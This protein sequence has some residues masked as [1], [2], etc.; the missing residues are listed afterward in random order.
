[1]RLLIVEDEPRM[2]ALLQRGFAEE[3]YA[4]DVVANGADSVIACSATEY[5]VVVLDVLLPDVDGFEVCHRLRQEGCW[6]PILML[7]ARDS[8]GDRV[9][10]L[11][12][13]LTITWSSPLAS[14]R[15]APAC[16]L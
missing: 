13:G 11:D 6:T 9:R 12:A 5:D 2:A 15:S 14:R 7:T 1:M 16:G 3:G 10:G 8:V 4:A